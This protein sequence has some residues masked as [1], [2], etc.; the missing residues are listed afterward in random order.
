MGALDE[1]TAVLT[2]ATS[3]IGAAIARQFI[4]EGARVVLAGRRES[5]GA[6]L[7]AELGEAASFRRTL[8]LGA[9]I[10]FGDRRDLQF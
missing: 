1:K 2:G 4:N 10:S 5:E 3:G 8:L 7:V 6:E 9:A